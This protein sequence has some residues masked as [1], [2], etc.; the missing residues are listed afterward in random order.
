MVTHRERKREMMDGGG[1]GEMLQG[2]DSQRGIFWKGRI[3]EQCVCVFS[4]L[5]L[6]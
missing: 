4:V 6:A 1:E 5:L 2:A 3:K